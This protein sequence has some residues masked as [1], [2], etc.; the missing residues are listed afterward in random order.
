[1]KWIICSLALL[2]ALTVQAQTVSVSPYSSLGLGEQLYNN[3]AEQ[4]AMGGISTVPTNPFGQN[5]NFSNPA[6]NQSIRMTNFNVSVRGDNSTLQ[7]GADKATTGSFKL[8]NI[9]LAFPMTKQSTFGIGFQPYTGLGYKINNENVVD[10]LNHQSAM[11]GNGG[12]NS[13]HAFYNYNIAKGFSIGVRA[14]YMFGELKTNEIVS[15]E[16]ASLVTDYD[17]KANYKGLQF[18]VG[19]MYQHKLGKNHNLYVGGY[20]TIGSNLNTDLREMT[21][22]YAYVGAN[23]ATIDTISLNRKVDLK[24]KIPQTVA[25]GAAYTKDNAWSIS[26]EVRYNTWGDF[27]KPTLSPA[28][29]ISSNTAYK[30]NVYLALGGYWIPDFNSYKSYF[31]RVIYRAGVY[32]ESA[33]YSIY[34]NDIN[35]Y[36]VTVGAGF[37][38]GK[39]N[40]GS[41]L[42]VSLEYGQKGTKNNGL[43]QE[44]YFGVKLGFDLNDIWFRKR[45][46]D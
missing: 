5:A 31:N 45:V 12:L 17:T 30:N 38:V 18:T 24:T 19:S 3:N 7:T 10:G 27:E 42:N 2:G 44:N 6:A 8:S 21:S 40:D 37:P 16:G 32:Y 15:I 1:M 35:R 39:M 11:E 29:T 43:I 36:G 13:I 22:T 41:M 28:T 25:L 33:P 46:I 14:N 26:G 20:Y 9:S 34:E 23:K 4:G